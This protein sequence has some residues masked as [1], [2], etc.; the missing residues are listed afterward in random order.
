[1]QVQCI[2]ASPLNRSD[3]IPTISVVMVTDT[4]TVDL[5]VDMLRPTPRP[6]DRVDMDT[7]DMVVNTRMDTVP[8]SGTG[9]DMVVDMDMA[10]DLDMARR[11][12]MDM[13]LDTVDTDKDL[14]TDTDLNM[15]VDMATI[16]RMRRFM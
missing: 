2:N 1:M 10:M 7:E 9:P 11:L 14:D 8:T 12:D 15:A 6:T 5:L 16:K 3:N 4:D 13:V